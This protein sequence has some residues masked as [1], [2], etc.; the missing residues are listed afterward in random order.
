MSAYVRDRPVAKM[1]GQPLS[2]LIQ[3]LWPCGG[4]SVIRQYR[5]SVQPPDE[6]CEVAQDRDGR[7]L[8]S[9]ACLG[10]C[11]LPFMVICEIRA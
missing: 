9:S 10:S 7:C 3:S 11:D 2:L 5:V 4:F 6:V 1:Q 8:E